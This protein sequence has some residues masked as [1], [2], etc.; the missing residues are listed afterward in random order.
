MSFVVAL[1]PDALEFKVGVRSQK[2]TKKSNLFE[3]GQRVSGNTSNLPTDNNLAAD[4][5]SRW[6]VLVNVSNGTYKVLQRMW[7]YRRARNAA[8][9][10]DER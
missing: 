1:F 3:T 10:A 5:C 9:K 4:T 6:A 7:A 8:E 2:V